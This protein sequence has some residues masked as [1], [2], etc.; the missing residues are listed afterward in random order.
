MRN[1][2]ELTIAKIK[3]VA[4][5]LAKEKM[6]GNEPIPDFGTRY[7]Q[8][9]ESCICTPFQS[10]NNKNLYPSLIKKA[11]V[12]FYLLIKNHPFKNGNKRIAMTSMMVFLYENKKWINVDPKEFYNFSM[13]VAQSPP[14]A[15]EEVVSFIEKFI[16]K[17][18]IDMI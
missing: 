10:F 1:I 14:D 4:F 16:K 18:L 9:L 2:K 8:K 15:K 5:E 6:S 3:H 7:P 11:S 17:N 13:W 12:L